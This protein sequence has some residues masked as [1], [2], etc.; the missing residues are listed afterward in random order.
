MQAEADCA[1]EQLQAQLDQQRQENDMLTRSCA[2]RQQQLESVRELQSEYVRVLDVLK[3]PVL[4]MSQVLQSVRQQND[5]LGED[6]VRIQ[7]EIKEKDNVID[8][9]KDMVLYQREVCDS[10]TRD[11]MRMQQLNNSKNTDRLTKIKSMESYLS[12]VQEA[13]TEQHAQIDE[14]LASK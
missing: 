12:T 6:I 5:V 4:E 3:A 10:L 14:A 8:V 13:V 7:E 2:E 1:K 9:L 11:L